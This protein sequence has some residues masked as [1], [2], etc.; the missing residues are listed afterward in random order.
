MKLIFLSYL[1]NGL[2]NILQ[3]EQEVRALQKALNLPQTT[4]YSTSLTQTNRP[5]L[6]N[7]SVLASSTCQTKVVTETDVNTNRESLFMYGVS[8]PCYNT[9]RHNDHPRNTPYGNLVW[10]AVPS[11]HP[12]PSNL[13]HDR[14]EVKRNH[15]ED[16]YAFPG[17]QD[18]SFIETPQLHKS[19][20]MDPTRTREYFDQFYN[21]KRNS[22]GDSTEFLRGKIKEAH[23][24]IQVQCGNCGN[25]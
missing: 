17:T 2:I 21:S 11:S 1:Q 24:T 15:V 10:E 22:L 6:L 12:F 25:E 23:W 9:L 14:G 16:F 19:H 20:M 3:Q 7:S 5:P 18:R 4:V 13:I 8:D